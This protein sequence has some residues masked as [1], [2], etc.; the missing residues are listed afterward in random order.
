MKRKKV[1]IKDL[2]EYVKRPLNKRRIRDIYYAEDII[3]E[4]C[5]LYMNFVET[6]CGYIHDTYLG[7]EHIKTIEDIE[8]HIK[9]CY[10][11]TRR[12]F[13]TYGFHFTFDDDLYKYFKELLIICYY[14]TNKVDK[15][16]TLVSEVNYWKNIL[17][18][19]GQKSESDL[20]DMVYLYHLFDNSLNP[21]RKDH[22]I[23]SKIETLK[24]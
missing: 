3:I 5:E 18:F 20:E 8:G 2:I 12:E 13:F 4:K 6:L 15:F 21:E 19:S 17:D 11:K 14:S 16:K 9:W 24:I 1:N 22:T 7:Q 10:N 23:D